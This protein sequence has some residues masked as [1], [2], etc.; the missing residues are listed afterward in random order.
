[1]ATAHRWR[2]ESGSNVA[3]AIDSVP[4]RGNTASRQASR[5]CGGSIETNCWLAHVREVTGRRIGWRDDFFRE[6]YR[7]YVHRQPI[8]RPR[9]AS[10]VDALCPRS[11]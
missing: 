7:G 8:T 3:A 2:R 5:A 11:S 4:P 1:M 6:I 9:L 10:R